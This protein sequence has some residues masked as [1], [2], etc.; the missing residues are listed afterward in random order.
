MSDEPVARQRVSVQPPYQRPT[1]PRDKQSQP[2]PPAAAPHDKAIPH[3]HDKAIPD[4]DQP[5][6]PVTKDFKLMGSFMMFYHLFGVIAFLL[7]AAVFFMT[8]ADVLQFF[9]YALYQKVLISL[10]PNYFNKDTMDFNALLYAKHNANT[11]PYNFYAKQAV[12]SVMFYIVGIVII[13]FIIQFCVFVILRT[14]AVM[15]KIKYHENLF[16]SQKVE[17]YGGIIVV[18]IMVALAYAMNSYYNS[19]F[20]KKLQPD[21]VTVSKNID[22]ISD[23]IYNNLTTNEKF[24]DNVLNENTNECIRMLNAQGTKYGSVGSMIFTMS[25]YN[26]FKV[27]VTSNDTVF[28]DIRKMF[29]I[30]G[31]RTRDVKAINYMYFNQN[32]FITDLYPILEEEISGK[33]KLLDTK[34]KARIVRTNSAD[35]VRSV[36]KL[37]TAVFALPVARF[38]LGWYI[39]AEFVYVSIFATMVG[40]TAFY[41]VTKTLANSESA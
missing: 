32:L 38:K 36:N 16:P 39:C 29:T 4:N 24:L 8:L 17:D 30:H 26:Y 37:F 21:I 19:M 13:F 7:V 41:T 15:N 40:A 20:L 28:N 11:E 12:I 27:N 23:T 1:P 6:S 14:M 34:E 18:G 31:I 5:P 25:L 22:N 9:G 35:R 33:G 2:D 3:Q 10:N